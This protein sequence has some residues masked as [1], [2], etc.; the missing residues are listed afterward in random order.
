M[1]I[2]YAVF[3]TIP[4]TH[5]LMGLIGLH[6]SIFGESENLASQMASKPNLLV[7]IALKGQK[8]I[9]Y[10]MGYSLDEKKFYSWLGGVDHL[11]RKHGVASNLMDKQHQYLREHGYK[12]VQTKTMNKWRSMLILNI[13]HGFEIIDTYIDNKGLHKIILEKIL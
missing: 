12:V 3:Q 9:G 11:Y 8:V 2:D 4:D 1:D 6:E 5:L 10:K 7:N 13:K